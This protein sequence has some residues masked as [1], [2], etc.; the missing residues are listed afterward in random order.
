MSS[1]IS[2]TLG[3]VVSAAFMTAADVFYCTSIVLFSFTHD[4]SQQAVLG[5]PMRLKG[6]R[7]LG[8]FG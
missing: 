1:S 2:H 8:K 6:R 5:G 4:E 3:T 7:R